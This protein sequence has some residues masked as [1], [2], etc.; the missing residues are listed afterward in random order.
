ML[1]EMNI[2]LAGRNIMKTLSKASARLILFLMLPFK[3]WRLVWRYAISERYLLVRENIFCKYAYFIEEG[4]TRSFWL[5][6]GEEITTSFAGE[7]SIVFSMDELY[8]QK[9]SEEF[10]ETLEEVVAYRILLT[11]L[12]HLLRRISNYATGEESYIRMNTGVCTAV[13][14]NALRFRQKSGMKHS[15]NSFRMSASASI[16]DLLLL[17][18]VLH[19]RRSAGC[20][21]MDKAGQRF[22]IGQT[23][24][25]K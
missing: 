17:I 12:I 25:R 3:R 14:R 15:R 18:W 21:Q 16:S 5:V 7:G 4:I 23:F 11:D 24:L 22:D 10:V 20:G 9:V 6:D 1:V 13:T 19:F 2:W 8:Y